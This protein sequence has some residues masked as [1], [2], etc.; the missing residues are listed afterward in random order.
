[1]EREEIFAVITNHCREVIGTLDNH[2]FHLNDR[3]KE[4]GANSIERAEIITL[5]L[6]S[7]A[8][9]IPRVELSGAETI[10]DLTEVVYDVLSIP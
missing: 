3:M 9:D 4:L 2:S 6:E 7:L 10:G 5:T 1:M 8:L